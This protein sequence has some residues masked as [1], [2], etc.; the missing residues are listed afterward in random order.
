[1]TLFALFLIQ[2]QINTHSHFPNFYE[3][4]SLG[5]IFSSVLSIH[6]KQRPPYRLIINNFLVRGGRRK[7][8]RDE[9]PSG[10]GK[11]NGGPLYLNPNHD[12]QIKPTD[13]FILGFSQGNRERGAAE[14][15]LVTIMFRKLN[16]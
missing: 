5:F 16:S 3:V 9:R 14:V 2:F 11:R 1:V 12:G 10:E 13:P 4:L 7:R 8:E 15:E 6:N